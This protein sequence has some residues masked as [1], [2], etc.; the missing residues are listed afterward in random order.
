MQLQEK[1]IVWKKQQTF[2]NKLNGFWRFGR[3]WTI[4]LI[5]WIWQIA[6]KKK[7]SSVATKFKWEVVS[8]KIP[9]VNYSMS[10]IKLKRI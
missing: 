2:K 8:G 9:S 1:E 4:I 5:V 6:F 7:P 10:F 3:I